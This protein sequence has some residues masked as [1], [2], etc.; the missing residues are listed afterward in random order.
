MS[1]KITGQEI[2][3]WS[4]RADS[5]LASKGLKRADVMLGVDAWTVAHKTDVIADAY[6]DPSIVDAHVQTALEQIFP[7]ASFKEPKRY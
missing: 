7:N 1:R 4:R 5:F 2:G 3:V 6:K